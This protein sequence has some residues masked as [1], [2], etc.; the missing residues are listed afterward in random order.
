MIQSSAAATA[1][2][3]LSRISIPVSASPCN[4]RTPAFATFSISPRCSSRLTIRLV[5]LM[6]IASHSLADDAPA[7]VG[8]LAGRAFD[9][10]RFA[11]D[12]D[13]M[14]EI[15]AH[16]VFVIVIGPAR[17][18]TT[19]LARTYR[20]VAIDEML[21][22]VEAAMSD[23]VDWWGDLPPP[24]KQAIEQFR[25]Q[26]GAAIDSVE[27]LASMSCTLIRIRSRSLRTLPSS[28]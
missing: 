21:R 17:P 16:A 3:S 25:I 8:H 1:G 18:E 23:V 28:T 10:L 15:A 22:T 5:S 19:A 26:L 2:R 13:R 27:V 11:I 9:Q 14:L 20:E 6:S 4:D 24:M 7:A 12:P